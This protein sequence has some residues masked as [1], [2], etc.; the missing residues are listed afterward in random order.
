MADACERV[1]MFFG[2]AICRKYMP[3]KTNDSCHL[4]N[5]KGIHN[6]WLVRFSF[7]GSY[8]RCNAISTHKLV[9]NAN[10]TQFNMSLVSLRWAFIVALIRATLAMSRLL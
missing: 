7:D 10:Q 4:V 8:G 6:N 9:C 1:F 5:Q 3:R 2:C